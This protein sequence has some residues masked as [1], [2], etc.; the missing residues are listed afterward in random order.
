MHEAH[1]SDI[2]LVTMPDPIFVRVIGSQQSRPFGNDSCHAFLHAAEV[3]R[4]R[5]LQ[6]QQFL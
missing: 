5:L 1:S 2:V 4:C 3:S 6:N